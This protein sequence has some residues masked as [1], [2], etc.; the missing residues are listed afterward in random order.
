VYSFKAR[1]KLCSPKKTSPEIHSDFTESTLLSQYVFKFGLRGGIFKDSTPP[2][3]IMLRKDLPNLNGSCFCGAIKYR[4]SGILRDARSCHCS[5]CRKEFSSQVSAYA[6]VK[7]TDFSW[8]SDES[9]LKSHESSKGASLQ[10]C[11][12]GISC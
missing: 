1:C 5:R 12:I 7:A 4:I 3:L 6:L 10:C 8:E 9:L 11:S 2:N